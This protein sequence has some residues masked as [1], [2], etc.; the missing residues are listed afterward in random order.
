MSAGPYAGISLALVA[1]TAYNVGLIQEKRALGR[2]PA[3]DVR[4]VPHMIAGLLTDPAWLA[5]FALMLLGLACQTI[6]LT[7]EPVSVVQPVLAS[8][9]ALVLVLSRLVLR[10]RLIPRAPRYKRFPCMT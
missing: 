7:F 9:V 2:M 3:L 1:T 5:G 10:E 4:R 6:V 8:G